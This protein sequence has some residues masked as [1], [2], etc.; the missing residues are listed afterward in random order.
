MQK[1]KPV[2]NDENIEYWKFLAILNNIR[3]EAWE[4]SICQSSII[5]I[6]PYPSICLFYR[7]ASWR[8]RFSTKNRIMRIHFTWFR[9]IFTW[10]NI[11]WTDEGEFS[12]NVIFNRWNFHYWSDTNSIH[13]ENEIFN[14]LDN[15]ILLFI[16]LE[17]VMNFSA[18]RLS[19]QFFVLGRKS[20]TRGGVKTQ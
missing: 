19:R 5:I 15:S 9:K 12:Q 16:V 20:Y 3:K 2:V 1:K 14:R 13:S 18:S 6:L 17:T 7:S 10:D 8:D 11:I 4:S